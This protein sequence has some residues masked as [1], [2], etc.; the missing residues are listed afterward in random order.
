[1]ALPPN[2]KTLENKFQRLNFDEIQTLVA[3]KI[4]QNPE[5]KMANLF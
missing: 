3:D 2:N 4:D 5:G 1:M